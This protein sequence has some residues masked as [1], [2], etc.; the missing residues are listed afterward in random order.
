MRCR[1]S[2]TSIVTCAMIDEDC[3]PAWLGLCSITRSWPCGPVIV[4]VTLEEYVASL[5]VACAP[6][7]YGLDE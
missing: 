5:N 7:Q 2:G 6:R 4:A 1:G 3:A